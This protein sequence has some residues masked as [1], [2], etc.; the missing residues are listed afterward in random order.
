MVALLSQAQVI[1][2]R[3]ETD[4]L[5]LADRITLRTNAVD[6]LLLLPNIG[7]EFDLGNKNWSR[8]SIGLDVRGNWQTK[9]TFKPGVVYNLAD[10]RGELRYYYRPKQIDNRK[11]KKHTRFLDRLFSCRRDTVKRPQLAYYRG[12]Y[13]SYSD[14]SFKFGSEG[15]QGSALTLGV[16]WGLVRPLYVFRNGHSFDFEL[17]IKV[18]LAYAKYDTYRHS[19]EDDCY[20][21]T[22]RGNSGIYPVVS[23]LHVGF[24]YRLGKYPSPSKYRWRYD[25]DYNFAMLQDSINDA[26]YRA[27]IN[28]QTEDSLREMVEKEFWHVYEA[29]AGVNKASADKLRQQQK[30]AERTRRDSLKAA[31]GKAG[32]A[33][34]D[35]AVA[36]KPAPDSLAAQPADTLSADTLLADSLAGNTIVP[37][38]SLPADSA[39]TDSV[40]APPADPLPADSAW[41]DSVA[42]PPADPLPADSVA[43]PAARGG[44]GAGEATVAEAKPDEGGDTTT[45]D[46]PGGEATAADPN[47]GKENGDEAQ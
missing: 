24:A 22:S 15:K 27:R 35:S 34:A 23:D 2:R 31:E 44:E 3:P 13:A 33:A 46:N 10:V 12:A 11:V 42:A 37:A 39:W 30:E 16:S 7:V 8:W 40:A 38:D 9:H 1:D 32:R 45:D 18:G 43:A 19:R 41:T 21:V 14:F 17:G 29:A 5:S 28:E 26:R 20:P 25:V 4:T 6:W 47:E 36:A